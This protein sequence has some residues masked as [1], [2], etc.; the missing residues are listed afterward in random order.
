[1]GR[2]PQRALTELRLGQASSEA[3]KVFA[4]RYHPQPDRAESA[5]VHQFFE[6]LYL[7]AGRGLHHIDEER[8]EAEEGALFW[9]LPGQRHDPGGL[10]ETRKWIVAFNAEAA[11]P[12]LHEGGFFAGP[13]PL[14]LSAFA[15]TGSGARSAVLP[16]AERAR[17]VAR[18]EAIAFEL[19][20][21]VLGYGEAACAHLRL[22]LLDLARL[23]ASMTPEAGAG[24]PLVHAVFAFIEAR[25]RLPIGLRDVAEAVGRSPA[26]LT[27]LIRR[28]T[29]RTVLQWVIDRRLA[30]ARRLLLDP[31]TSVAQVA[32]EVGYL[33]PKHFA[34]QFRRAH[35]A[36]PQAWR[37]ARL[38]GGSGKI[39]PRT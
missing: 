30:E 14:A 33:D 11:A 28:E 36:S 39:P 32:E 20:T 26:Y 29:G 6:L 10:R 37:S 16:V 13:G 8:F 38:A 25:F 12:G 34:Q 35:G 9:M 2:L 17:W 7:E 4:R 31:Q 23:A 21:K 19:E 24:R 3:P 27:D 1:M 18:F 22:V 15:L 5:H